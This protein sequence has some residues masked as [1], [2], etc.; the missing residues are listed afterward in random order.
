M[1]RIA[2]IFK[3]ARIYLADAEG[4]RWTDSVLLYFLNEALLDIVEKAQLLVG[5]HLIELKPGVATFE[6]PD[7]FIKLKRVEFEEKELPVSSFRELD[8]FNANQSK[9][10]VPED[11]ATKQGK[12]LLLIPDLDTHNTFRIYPIPNVEDVFDVNINARI[13]GYG[14][15]SNNLGVVDQIGG[16]LSS[17][18]GAATEIVGTD[19]DLFGVLYHID[20]VDILKPEGVVSDLLNATRYSSIDTWG[21]TSDFVQREIIKVTYVKK[22]KEIVTILDELPINSQFDFLIKDFLV[23]KAYENNLDEGSMQK[24]LLVKKQY[25][26]NLNRVIDNRGKANVSKALG[27]DYYVRGI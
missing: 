5:E 2:T 25:T 20:G 26:D 12:P 19:E 15:V 6:L 18:F 27:G 4:A 24:S 11:W 23:M 22:P 13:E 1:N 8:N 9:L 17:D 14:V 7:D 3:G 21:V 10:S 16:A